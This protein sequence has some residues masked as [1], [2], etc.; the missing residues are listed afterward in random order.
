KLCSSLPDRLD[1]FQVIADHTWRCTI[2]NTIAIGVS[3][4]IDQYLPIRWTGRIIVEPSRDDQIILIIEYTIF[5]GV[6]SEV[7][8]TINKQAMSITGPPD[9]CSALSDVA[10]KEIGLIDRPFTGR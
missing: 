9:V 10:C 2:G 6:F 1:V 8:E 4:F 5:Y 3:K 7:S